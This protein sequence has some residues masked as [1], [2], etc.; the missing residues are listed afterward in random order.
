VEVK[1]KMCDARKNLFGEIEKILTPEQLGKW[2]LAIAK[3]PNPC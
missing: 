2:K 1:V 3:I